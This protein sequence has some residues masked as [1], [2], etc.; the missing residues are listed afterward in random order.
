MKP[1]HVLHSTL[2]LK[3]G[4]LESIIMN[5]S[6]S[7][8]RSHFKLSVLC[9]SSFD[10][11]Y[12]AILDQ[13]GVSIYHI[14]RKGTFDSSFFKKI[15]KLI[16]KQDVGILHAHSGCFFNSALCAKLSS[17]KRFVYT[18]HGL[19]MFDNGLPMNTALKTRLEDKFAAST[20]DCIFA[21]SD[22][23]KI[24]MMNRFPRSMKKVRIVTNGVN[25]DLFK[26]ISG[27]EIKQNFKQRFA[28]NEKHKLIGSVGRLVPIKNYENL[29]RAFASLTEEIGDVG[30]L[31]L[32]GDG[33]ER[34]NLEKCAHTL[35]IKHL[36][37]FAGVQYDIQ[38]ILPA[39]DIFVLP[40][41]TE[42]T[43]ISLLE[44]QSCGVPAVV[45]RVGGNQ[46]IVTDGLNGF[47]FDPDDTGALTERLKEML[48]DSSM[49][50]R[51]GTSAR[52]IV[53]NTYSVRKMVKDYESAYKW[54]SNA[55]IQPDSGVQS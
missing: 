26:P 13:N 33:V 41:L 3:M 18:E 42:G 31:V 52:E 15:V 55:D 7:M 12:K 28:I 10:E 22:E 53:E 38:D 16:K 46:S 50:T 1:I 49:R 21:V 36:V 47:L 14:K 35:G 24:D 19:P 40:S 20:A 27:T 30:H 48:S 43:S 29:L 2:F 9:L 44:A 5:L 11:K 32:I 45:S 39:L 34:Q 25:T 37:T 6:E 4:G 8:D 17:V 54:L 23:I 51:M